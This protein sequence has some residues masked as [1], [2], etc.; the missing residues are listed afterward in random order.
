MSNLEIVAAISGARVAVLGNIKGRFRGATRD[1]REGTGAAAPGLVASALG[2]VGD[3]L[4]LGSFSTV[5]VT[6]RANPRLGAARQGRQG[7][8]R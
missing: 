1:G 2:Q 7:L 5:S 8:S 3:L 6:A 4:G